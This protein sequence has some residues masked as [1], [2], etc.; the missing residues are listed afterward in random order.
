MSDMLAFFLT[1]KGYEV[2]LG[3]MGTVMTA[4]FAACIW[5]NGTISTGELLQAPYRHTSACVEVYRDQH[6][7]RL[8]YG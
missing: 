5:L 1:D 3:R 2:H 8:V 4:S 7:Q 6:C